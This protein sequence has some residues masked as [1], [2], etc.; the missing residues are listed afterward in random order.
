MVF[1]D[2][3]SY[4]NLHMAW[5]ILTLFQVNGP[6]F[7]SNLSDSAIGIFEV[8]LSN[9]PLLVL[10]CALSLTSGLNFFFYPIIVYF[11][12]NLL[13][14]IKNGMSRKTAELHSSL[15]TAIAA[16][17]AILSCM[18]STTVAIIILMYWFN[19]ATIGRIRE[20]IQ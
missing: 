17:V 3:L 6:D 8:S 20:E 16:Q 18:F 11:A 4:R 5:T 15:L 10:T 9:I 7:Y 14:Q 2:F 19:W 13:N 1:S 12:F